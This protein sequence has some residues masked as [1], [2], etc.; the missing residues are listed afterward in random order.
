MEAIV[1]D[2]ME[3]TMFLNFSV[4]MPDI[5]LALVISRSFCSRMNF[6]SASLALVNR[7]S[8]DSYQQK[9]KREREII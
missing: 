4:S 3:S 2:P 6:V 1:S 5:S 7:S 9:R 8:S